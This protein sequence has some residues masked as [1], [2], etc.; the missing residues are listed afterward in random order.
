[1]TV[2]GPLSA[3]EDTQPS[4]ALPP[5]VFEQDPGLRP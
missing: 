3:W 4:W 1:V 5:E 2:S